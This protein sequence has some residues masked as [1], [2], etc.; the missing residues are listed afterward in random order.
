MKSHLS[1]SY[2]HLTAAIREQYRLFSARCLIRGVNRRHKQSWHQT[3]EVEPI[4]SKL[5]MYGI[6]IVCCFIAVLAIEN[7]DKPDPKVKIVEVR[8]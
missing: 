7:Y 4:T 8:K 5:V 3:G 1:K 6:A 2:Q